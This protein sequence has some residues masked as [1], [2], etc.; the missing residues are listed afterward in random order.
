MI[1]SLLQNGDYTNYRMP[2]LNLRPTGKLTIFDSTSITRQADEAQALVFVSLFPFSEDSAV[3]SAM[4]NLSK[5]SGINCIPKHILL[6]ISGLLYMY[7]YESRG[8]N[9]S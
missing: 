9:F 4:A 2:F 1:A 5:R 3:K 7:D 8:R 6:Y